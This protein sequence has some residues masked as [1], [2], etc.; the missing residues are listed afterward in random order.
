MSSS[1][2]HGTAAH[3]D[4][5]GSIYSSGKHRGEHGHSSRRS[6]KKRDRLFKI[7]ADMSQKFPLIQPET[8]T[9]GR[10]YLR[11]SGLKARFRSV[12]TYRVHFSTARGLVMKGL[13]STPLLWTSALFFTHRLTSVTPDI[14]LPCVPPKIATF[15]AAL[16]RTLL[17]LLLLLLEGEDEEVVGVEDEE[18]MAARWTT[19]RLHSPAGD[20]GWSRRLRSGSRARK[21]SSWSSAARCLNAE[22]GCALT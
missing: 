8:T 7:T 20:L 21:F 13:V 5:P 15:L 14:S 16:R 3:G 11:F 4:I 1:Q 10:A 17:L 6:C 12:S 22:R 18:D 2:C 19:G 9:S